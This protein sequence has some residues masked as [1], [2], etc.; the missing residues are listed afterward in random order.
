MA[1]AED[2][3]L[4]TLQTGDQARGWDAVGQLDI[5]GR[6]FCSGALIADNLVLTAAHCLFDRETNARIDPATIQFLAGW[7]G[8]RAQSYRGV[9]R[10]VVHPDY[11]M[12]GTVTRTAV[13][14]A[15][16]EL[17]R[18]IRD[19]KVKPFAI[20]SRP[21]AGE[22][23]GVVSYARGRDQAPS[24]QETCAVLGRQMG[25]VVMSCDV[26][27]GASGAPIFSFDSG[28][29]QIVS[30]VSAMATMGDKK[31]SLGTDL[32]EPLA[33]IRA[34][35]AAG[36]GYFLPQAPEPRRVLMSGQRRD[37]GAKFVKP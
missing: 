37:T 36:K 8:G 23:V 21:R 15:V 35:L 6:G 14:V 34:E 27:F 16:L 7:R 17:D 3:P 32:E 31:V 22:E 26:D 9:R 20:A 30:V 19:T 12:D 28:E 1:V 33:R 24:I 4:A 18:P 5:G 10:A 29:P 11:V 25:S 13:D 2:S